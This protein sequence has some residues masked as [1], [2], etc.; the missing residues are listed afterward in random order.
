M[1]ALVWL[2]G[3]LQE[4]PPPY[5]IF[6]SELFSQNDTFIVGVCKVTN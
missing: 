6:S 5:C 4:F 3:V 1:P 2:P